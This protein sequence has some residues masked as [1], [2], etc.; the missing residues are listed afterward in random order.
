MT[1]DELVLVIPRAS[2]M[3]DPGWRGI[4]TEGLDAFESIVARDGRFQ[5]RAA[6]EVDR[7]WKQVIPYL[8]LRDRGRLFLMRRTRAGGDARLHERWSIGIGGHL[9]PEDGDV[10]SGLAR[11]FAEELEADWTPEPRL[12]G[13]LNDDTD[14]VG[15]V[16]LGVVFLAEAAGRPVAIRETE[17]LDGAFVAPRDVLRVYDRLETWSRLLYDHMTER[18]SG[19]RAE[20]RLRPRP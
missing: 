3:A 13:L 12:I 2:I 14:P 7:R 16:H 20:G 5:P 11:E 18:A 6:M 9:N 1:A 4:R 10:V 8:V 15:A 19:H 17:K